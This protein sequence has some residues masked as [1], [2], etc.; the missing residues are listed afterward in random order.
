[1]RHD[2][3]PPAGGRSPGGAAAAPELRSAHCTT[4]QPTT[5]P[6][7]PVTPASAMPDDAAAETAQSA[8]RRD[9]ETEINRAIGRRIRTL[10]L[11]RG[12]S[13]EACS[14]QL[15]ISFQQL[16]KY[17]KGQNRISACALYRLAGILDV[18]PS[19]LL[20]RLDDG[21][22]VLRRNRISR[23]MIEASTRLASISDAT[24]RRA[25]TDLIAAL[26][27]AAA[28]GDAEAGD[29]DLDLDQTGAMH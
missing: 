9:I 28:A 11:A 8:N 12:F 22:K 5:A 15:G 26:S 27:S 24:A 13:Q 23:G 19:A 10:R 17:E 4:G 18:P 1:M 29:D 7:G 21:P 20:D 14:T 6:P 3:T 25:I 2:I 16:Q